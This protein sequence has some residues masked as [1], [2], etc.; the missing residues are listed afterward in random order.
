MCGIVGYAGGKSAAGELFEGLKKLEYRGD[1]PAGITTLGGGN[2]FTIKNLP[3]L[4]SQHPLIMV[5][6]L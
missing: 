1:D 6:L 3:F 4:I 5:I 2:N